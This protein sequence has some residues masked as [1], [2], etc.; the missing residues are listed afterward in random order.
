MF[1][2]QGKSTHIVL[3]NSCRLTGC[4]RA[5]AAREAGWPSLIRVR[6]RPQTRATPNISPPWIFFGLFFIHSLLLRNPCIYKQSKA[7]RFLGIFT[8]LQKEMEFIFCKHLHPTTCKQLV[9]CVWVL[10]FFFFRFK[11]DFDDIQPYTAADGSPPSSKHLQDAAID[12]DHKCSNMQTS[13]HFIVCKNSQTYTKIYTVSVMNLLIQIIKV[14][15]AAQINP[16]TDIDTQ[17]F[18]NEKQNS[19]PSMRSFSFGTLRSPG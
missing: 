13:Q 1:S 19:C 18:D 14:W 10:F 4:G 9:K 6:A 17:K 3:Y 7:F 5:T 12:I 15:I 11:L 2:N 16:V 8:W